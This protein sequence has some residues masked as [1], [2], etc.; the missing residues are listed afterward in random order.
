M[1]HQLLCNPISSIFARGAKLL[2]KMLKQTFSHKSQI[3]DFTI[4]FLTMSLLNV[5]CWPGTFL[6]RGRIGN[7]HGTAPEQYRASALLEMPY[8]CHRR[9]A[10]GMPLIPCHWYY[11]FYGRSAKTEPESF[12]L[13]P[14]VQD[15]SGL[16]ICWSSHFTYPW[17]SHSAD[18]L[19]QH[20]GRF[21]HHNLRPL[22]LTTW[23][24]NGCRNRV[25]IF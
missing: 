3:G 2:S 11:Q 8:W 16:H 4:G 19:I 13:H 10:W 12:S 1:V 5:E 21:K 15:S 14:T 22:Q 18:F 6:P 25:L 20:K 9:V 24:L 7:F 17:T 23:Y